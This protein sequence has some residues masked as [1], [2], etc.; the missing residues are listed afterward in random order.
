MSTFINKLNPAV[1]KIWLHLASGLMWSGVGIMLVAFAARWLKLSGWGTMLA[2]ILGGATLGALI[3][4]FGFSKLAHKNICRIDLFTKSRICLFAFQ[5]WKSY[6][7]VA[8]MM[9][10]GIYLRIYSPIP[11]PVLAILY[12][13]LG[14]SLF[15]SSIQYYQRVYSMGRP[16]IQ[17]Q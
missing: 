2:L 14:F 13:G 9:G 15:A 12:L 4:Y 8:F 7:L 17:G 16:G 1:G 11:K 10:F 6:P 3:Y 5:G